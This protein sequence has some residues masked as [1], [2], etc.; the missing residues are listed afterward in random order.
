MDKSFTMLIIGIL[1]IALS[2]F[3]L[4]M[5]M[6]KKIKCTEEIDAEI[7]DVKKNRYGRG[8]KNRRSTDY[9]PVVKYIV[10]GNECGGVAEISSVLPNKFKIGESITVKYDPN[11]PNSF[12]VKGKIGNAK[13]YMVMIVV[14]IFIVV[15]YFR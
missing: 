9:S 4:W 14:G 15:F 1:F 6:K 13:W 8:S 3:L 12:C 11:D 2:A 5:S 10:S 7:I